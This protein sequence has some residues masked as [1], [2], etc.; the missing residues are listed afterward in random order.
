MTLLLDILQAEDR[1]GENT[2]NSRLHFGMDGD[3]KSAF[4]PTK[5]VPQGL[6]LGP[7]FFTMCINDIANSLNGCFIH[8]CSLNFQHEF[9]ALKKTLTDLKHNFQISALANIP[10]ERVIQFGHYLDRH[11]GMICLNSTLLYSC[12]SKSLTSAHPNF[13]SNCFN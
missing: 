7:V 12:H 6:I 3:V 5:G 2:Q 11:P 4:L 8:C 13:E 9:I 1:G 10:T